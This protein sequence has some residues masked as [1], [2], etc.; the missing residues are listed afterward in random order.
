M[1]NCHCPKCAT[2]T[3]P[4]YTN[5]FITSCEA[6]L[7]ISLDNRSKQ[8]EYLAKVKEKRGVIAERELRD[9][10]NAELKQRKSV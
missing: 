5:E 3:S 4:T 2:V 10:I 9:A 6:R 1:T 8:D 7:I